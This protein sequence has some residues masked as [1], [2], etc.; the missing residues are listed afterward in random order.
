MI[1]RRLFIAI[2][3]IG[4]IV[5]VAFFVIGLVKFSTAEEYRIWNSGSFIGGSVTSVTI[6]YT[7]YCASGILA[8]KMMSVHMMT[9]YMAFTYSSLVV[10]VCT[11]VLW[12]VKQFQVKDVWISRALVAVEIVFGITAHGNRRLMMQE[13]METTGSKVVSKREDGTVVTEKDEQLEGLEKKYMK[14]DSAV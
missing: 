2:N 13:L 8:L 14:K 7:L 6:F 3:I 12:Q 5:S 1:T 4:I 9:M 11:L 10:R